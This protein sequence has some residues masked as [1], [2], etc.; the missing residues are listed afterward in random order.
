MKTQKAKGRTVR[1]RARQRGFSN[2]PQIFE[3]AMVVTWFGVTMAGAKYLDS[4][5]TQRRA[6]ENAAQDSVHASASP[7]QSMP[8][9]VDLGAAGATSKVNLAS[10]DL[11]G[12]DSAL[13]PP[14]PVLGV[15]YEHAF[16]SQRTPLRHTTS[17][18]V[19]TRVQAEDTPNGG[20]VESVKTVAASRQMSCQDIP[21]PLPMPD[22]NIKSL[23]S[24][25]WARN[26]MGY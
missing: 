14:V 23:S 26:V 3:L 12:L 13:L 17:A 24:V 6:A 22:L 16:P 11:L 15:A 8:A 10:V 9:G 20:V 19:S 7:C 4:T 1:R 25:I 21:Q 18:A 2:A 5:I